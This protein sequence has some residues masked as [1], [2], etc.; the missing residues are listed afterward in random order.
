MGKGKRGR[1]GIGRETRAEKNGRRLVGGSGAAFVLC[2]KRHTL[3]VYG[4]IDR[5]ASRHRAPGRKHCHMSVVIY[6]EK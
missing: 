1:A 5:A 6:E 2:W 4:K 3:V